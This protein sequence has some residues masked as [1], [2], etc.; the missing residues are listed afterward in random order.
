MLATAAMS[1]ASPALA[2][3]V[4]PVNR[5]ALVQQNELRALQDRVQRQQ[6][7]QQQQQYR[8]QDRQIVPQPRPVVPQVKPSCQTQIIGTTAL[9]NCR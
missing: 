3:V 7:Q 9:N 8:S 4:N 1:G 2:Q 5:N 6:F